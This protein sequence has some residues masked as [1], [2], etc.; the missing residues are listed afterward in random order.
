MDNGILFGLLSM[1]G[2]GVGN[3]LAQKV[4]RSIGPRSTIFFREIFIA[5]ILGVLLFFTRVTFSWQ[6][7]I[8]TL[9]LAFIGY[10][11]IMAFYVALHRGKAGVIAPISNASLLITVLLSVLVLGE[12]LTTLRL[13][14]IGVILVGL[15]L[16]AL[17]FH[18]LRRSEFLDVSSGVPHAIA[19]CIIWGVLFFIYTYPVQALGA[20][21]T[22]WTL[23][24]GILLFAGIHFLISPGEFHLP[25]QKTTYTALGLAVLIAIGS[26]FYNYGIAL[27]SVSIVAALSMSN[28]AVTALLGALVSKERLRPTQYIALVLI[29]AGIVALAF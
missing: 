11:G 10:L 15:V 9:G 1:A 25:S 18:D 16:I 2:F 27:G 14:A 6:Y 3:Y 21:L 8:I 22:A 17:N 5:V 28:P 24:L 4:S 23:E 29:I 26:V 7:I 20:T 12:S 19:A 13:A